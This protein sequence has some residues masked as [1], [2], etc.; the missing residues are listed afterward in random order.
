MKPRPRQRAGYAG[1]LGHLRH[2]AAVIAGQRRMRVYGR[3]CA[4]EAVRG[5]KDTVGAE[6][7]WVP[8][9]PS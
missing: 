5:I 3:C 6:A 2:C 7:S 4:G 8:G 1:V 9:G